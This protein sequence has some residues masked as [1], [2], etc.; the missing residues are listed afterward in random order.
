ML[1]TRRMFA[2]GTRYFASTPVFLNNSNTADPT[3]FTKSEG[4]AFSSIMS[5]HKIA[6]LQE[7]LKV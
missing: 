7:Q 1:R 5:G 2:R 6:E 4:T 3:E